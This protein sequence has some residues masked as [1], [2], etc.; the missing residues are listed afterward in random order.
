[1]PRSEEVLT[2]WQ[3]HGLAFREVLKIA[4]GVQVQ[5]S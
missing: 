3:S 4:L 5:E 2:F 1:M